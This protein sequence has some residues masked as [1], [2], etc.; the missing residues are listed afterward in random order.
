MVISSLC[1]PINMQENNV[2]TVLCLTQYRTTKSARKS[3]M[4]LLL[5]SLNDFFGFRRLGYLAL[6]L[7]HI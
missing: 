5:S 6:M 2:L 4:C 3:G 1:K 7:A